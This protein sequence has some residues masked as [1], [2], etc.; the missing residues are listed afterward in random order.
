MKL[1]IISLFLLAT[2]NLLANDY[3]GGVIKNGEKTLGMVCISYDNNNNCEEIDIIRDSYYTIGTLK[4]IPSDELSKLVNKK[5]KN[6]LN[7][8]Y[9]AAT[10]YGSSYAFYSGTYPLIIIGSGFDIIKAPLVGVAFVLNKFSDLGLKKRMAKLLNFM[11]DK[12]K[13]G[14]TKRTRKRYLLS[15][16]ESFSEYSEPN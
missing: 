2:T 8:S 13:I 12:N 3:M 1:I 5:A 15:L 7:D 14:K 9:I 10:V 16:N 6:K 11:Q 4:R